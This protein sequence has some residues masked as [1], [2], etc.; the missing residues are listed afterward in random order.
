[1][2]RP[3]ATILLGGALWMGAAEAQGPPPGG[4]G[5]PGGGMQAGDGIWRRN[6]VYGEIQTLDTCFGHQPGSGEYHYHANPVCLRAQLDDNIE[7][8]STK[9]VGTT[10]RER[11]APWKHSPLLGWAVDGYPIYGPY[12]YADA[13]NPSSSVRRI[14]SSFRLRSIT[15]RNALPTWSLASHTGVSTTLTDSQR[16]PAITPEFPLG[17][18]VEDFEYLSSFGDLDQYNGR[19]GLT[20]EFPQGTYAYFITIEADGTPA[21][22][23]LVGDQYYG[24]ASGGRAPTIPSA[25]L[26]FLAN[27]TSNSSAAA[28]PSLV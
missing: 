13:A 19:F 21:F 15:E 24:A 22:P 9:R 16:G 28:T 8:I 17:R 1:M 3:L 10:Y 6:A 14:R 26:T 20:P 4:P 27:G 18:Y 23:Y 2:N 11:P 25:A 7:V 12:G 5:G